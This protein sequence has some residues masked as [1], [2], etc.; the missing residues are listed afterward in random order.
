MSL[1][2][3]LDAG[4]G[5]DA[6]YRGGLSD[7]RP[8]ALVALQALGADDAR[9]AA[10]A[11]AYETHLQPAP[12]DEPWPAGD[13]WPGRFGERSAWP[14]YRDLFR[15]WIAHEGADA[16]L[17]QTLPQ[18]MPGCAAAA[19]HGLLRTAYAVVAGHAD[20]LA[21]GLAYWACRHLPLDATAGAGDDDDDAQAVL[22]ALAVSLEPV[23]PEGLIF[24]RMRAVARQ[25]SFAPA[26]A[27][28]RVDEATLPALTRLAT[29]LYVA[30]GDFTVLH[31]V[32]GCHAMHVVAPFQPDPL[33]AAR[34]F[35]AAWLAG[36]A[37]SGV[38]VPPSFDA[39]AP[40]WPTLRAAATASDDAHV[41]KLVWS[42]VDL[43]RRLGPDPLYGA[44]AA[45]ALA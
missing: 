38:R 16:V 19:F 27:R 36:W 42:A 20:E 3:L 44:A 4:A 14:A 15:D 9:L 26:V 39:P 43:D 18:L 2:A 30:S 13:A 22:D 28:L 29:G 17:E 10:F 21:D 45:R 37:A 6:E 34:H 40:D 23:P 11:A 35:A 33:D 5:F 24:E 41:V 12:P 1:N 32:T 31:L 7:H 25:P 8:M